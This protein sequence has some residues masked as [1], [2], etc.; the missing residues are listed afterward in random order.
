[1][2]IQSRALLTIAGLLFTAACSDNASQQSNASAPVAKADVASAPASNSNQP[3]YVVVSQASYPPFA[4]RGENGEMVGLDIDILNAIAAKEG[5]KLSFI[6]HKM[7][8]LLETLDAGTADIVATGVNITPEREKIYDFSVPYLEGSWVALLNK[9]KNQ[10]SKWAEL[11][12]KTVAVQ[13][14]SLSETQ[15]KNTGLNVN[16]MPVKTVYLGL[17]EVNSGNAVAVY[18]VDS[19]LNTYLTKGSPLY[20]VV[21]EKSGKIPFGF[22]VKKGNAELK[23]K[24]DKGIADI[25]ADGTYQKIL[26]KWYPKAN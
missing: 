8:G 11:Q 16:P 5:F 14:A 23:A 4:T 6:P 17:K 13:E 22:V 3:S 10:I 9:D 26:D 25:K 19:V 2:N 1:M 21:D 12:G 20:T 18:D 7:D 15:L 24:L